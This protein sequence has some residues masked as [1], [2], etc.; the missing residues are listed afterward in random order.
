MGQN[1]EE[2]ILIYRG[3]FDDEYR[4]KIEHLPLP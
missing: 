4:D 1:I 2:M 3:A